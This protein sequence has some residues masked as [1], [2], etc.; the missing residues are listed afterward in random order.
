MPRLDLDA[1]NIPWK[2]DDPCPCLR[3]RK[4]RDCCY[5]PNALPIWDVGNL[6]PPG[7]VTGLSNERCFMKSAADCSAELSREHYISRSII[8]QLDEM[9]VEGAPWM[10]E[11]EAKVYGK[12]ALTARVLCT[13]HN[14]ALSPLDYA[15]G[16]AFRQFHEAM[17][18]V[19]KNSLARRP[20]HFLVSGDGL[21]FWG[22]KTLAAMFVGKIASSNG[23]AMIK[24]HELDL[25][26]VSRSLSGE[27]PK[28]PLGM[29]FFP[30][31]PEQI[32]NDIN[33]QSLSAK[34]DNV[35]CGLRTRWRGVNLDFI[36]DSAGMDLTS[37][38]EQDAAYRPLIL[39]L[40]GPKRSSRIIF[41]WADPVLTGPRISMQINKPK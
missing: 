8:S 21:E 28:P 34:D 31:R 7:P 25:D 20:K 11:G 40:V 38:S 24:D 4:F 29:Y 32:F 14:N 41:S 27:S 17:D 22:I 13:R 30:G 10:E 19:K 33:I 5:R 37:Y 1:V 2:P 15:A 9:L 18:Y 36:A 12:N 23:E 16:Q 39:D 6:I 3:G 35:M 26:A